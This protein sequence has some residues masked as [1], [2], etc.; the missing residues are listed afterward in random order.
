MGI[1]MEIL[2]LPTRFLSMAL[3]HTDYSTHWDFADAAEA[4]RIDTQKFLN[5]NFKDNSSYGEWS[6]RADADTW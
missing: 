2:F 1:C 5:D 4:Y 3:A 6:Y